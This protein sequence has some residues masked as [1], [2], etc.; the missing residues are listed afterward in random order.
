M[1]S[2]C[3]IVFPLLRN[4]A[5]VYAGTSVCVCVCVSLFLPTNLPVCLLISSSPPTLLDHVSKHI[6]FFSP[7]SALLCDQF[8]LFS[9]VPSCGCILHINQN[10]DAENKALRFIFIPNVTSLSKGS[11][12]FLFCESKWRKKERKK[13]EEKKNETVIK[14]PDKRMTVLC[15]SWYQCYLSVFFSL[16][17]PFCCFLGLILLHQN[18][19]NK[20]GRKKE[21][22]MRIIHGGWLIKCW[23]RN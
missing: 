17:E 1:I 14:S 6:F 3:E 5:S 9:S 2:L 15:R 18:A 19:R 7:Q 12:P 11:A 20:K 21:I 10:E 23:C 13:I 16:C 8:Y 22:T 4:M